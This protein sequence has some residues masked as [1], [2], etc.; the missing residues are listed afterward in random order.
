MAGK[1]KRARKPPPKPSVSLSDGPSRGALPSKVREAIKTL[2]RAP[3]VPKPGGKR[4]TP[5]AKKYKRPIPVTLEA[6]A[7]DTEESSYEYLRFAAG[8]VYTTD[9]H[10]IT[11]DALSKIAPYNRVHPKTIDIWC[12]K[13]QWVARRAQIQLDWR[14]QIERKIGQEVVQQAITDLDTTNTLFEAAAEKLATNAA[15]PHSYEGMLN[16]SIKLMEWRSDLREK[17]YNV[18]APT[19]GGSAGQSA[20]MPTPNFSAEEARAAAKV[21]IQLRREQIRSEQEKHDA[22]TLQLEEA[23]EG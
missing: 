13:D 11:L 10:G 15:A 16:A 23:N 7:G 12:A 14:K 5:T 17:I 1:K 19:P 4:H 22:E 20:G 21:I 6:P 2:E 3:Q 9:V 18:A 8:I